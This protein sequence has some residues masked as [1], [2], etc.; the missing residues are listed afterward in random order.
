MTKISVFRLILFSVVLVGLIILLAQNLSPVLPLVFL[1]M[2]TQALPIGLWILF[3]IIAG[4]LTFFII[5][6][7]AKFYNNL[8]QPTSKPTSQSQKVSSYQPDRTAEK[9]DPIPSSRYTREYA[10]EYGGDNEDDWELDDTQGDDWDFDARKSAREKYPEELID[11]SVARRSNSNNT[12]Y[13]YS[14]DSPANTGVGKVESIFDADYRVI[15]PPYQSPTNNEEENSD[16][17]WSFFE[18]D[19]FEENDQDKKDNPKS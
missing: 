6:I 9:K 3:S 18:D 14:S 5:N 12:T 17:D 8:S 4:G 11:E 19:D 15:I 16:D 10:P 13:S 7:L 2:K 1:G